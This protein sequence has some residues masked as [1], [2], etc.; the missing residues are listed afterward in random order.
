MKSPLK[1]I[2]SSTVFVFLAIITITLVIL[3]HD[4]T[5]NHLELGS[6]VDLDL[7]V[8]S[9][10]GHAWPIKTLAD[11]PLLLNFW[12]PWCP[13]CVHEMPLLQNFAAKYAE[14]LAV[15]GV[16]IDSKT[17][18][19]A[20]LV[21]AKSIR[22]PIAEAS[23]ALAERFHVDQL[24]FTVLIQNKHVRWLHKGILTQR[25]FRKIEEL[26]TVE[27]QSPLQTQP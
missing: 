9:Y 1:K 2:A 5:H 16:A 25:E 21:R 11:N 17:E 13:S 24:P 7:E 20:T 6:E 27:P 15:L 8:R 3:D 12:A 10:D 22:Y 19:V 14:W 23:D 18:E 4:H 26:L